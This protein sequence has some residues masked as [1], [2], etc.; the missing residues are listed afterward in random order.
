[1]T[2]NARLLFIAVYILVGLGLVMTY[3]S[4]AIYA[5]HVYKNSYHFLIRQFLYAILG[6]FFLFLTASVPM[7]FWQK[8]SR[9]MVFLTILFL[10]IVFIPV[11][12]KQAGGA[13]RW[14][15]LG[16]I[17]FQPAEFAKIAVAIYMADYLARKKRNTGKGGLLI[18]FPPL[19]LVGL[20]C[21]LTLLQPDLGS[22]VFI[23]L[24]TT[25]LIFLAGIQLRY[26]LGAFIFIIPVFYF[27]VLSVPY[28]A[29][30][31]TAYLNPWN[32]PEG[33]G[34]QII[35]SLL[36]FGIG[37]IK[38]TGLGQGIQKLF[39]LPSSYND[40]IFSIIGEELG[41][42]GM[43]S[44]MAL[45]GVIFYCGLKIA[46][47]AKHDFEKYLAY[48]LTVA[49]V[50]QALINMMVTTG[51]IPTKGLPLPFVSFGG[52]A[53]MFN[54]MGVGLLMAIDRSVKGAGKR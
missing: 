35:Q 38:G 23:L 40:F 24:I 5:G 49:I 45:Y 26:A 22:C 51:L 17:N 21:G 3:S 28:R 12:G 29:S 25:T 1:M 8:N 34:F 27:L 9:V 36:A 41:L 44:V 18:Y 30:R 7:S 32:D 6:T 48:A 14:I 16:P 47:A 4:S 31:V 39:Y 37:G 15:R 52:T 46:K 43:T 11:I 20:V 50:L 2:R 10:M 33:S 19:I 13:Q 53:L 54:L 42:L